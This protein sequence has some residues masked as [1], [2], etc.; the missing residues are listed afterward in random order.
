MIEHAANPVSP[1][2]MHLAAS[3]PYLLN[4]DVI[5]SFDPTA[6]FYAVVG[7]GFPQRFYQTLEH[8]GLQQFQCHEF[9]DHHDYEIEDLQFDDNSP[10]ITTEKMQLKLWHYSNSIQIISGISGWCRSM[11]SCHLPVIQYCSSN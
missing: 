7:I 8:L 6:A 10:I 9:P 4:Q 2:H 11:Q 1:L 3:Q 5:K